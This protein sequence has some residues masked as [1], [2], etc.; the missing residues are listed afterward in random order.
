MSLGPLPV[1]VALLL[2]MVALLVAAGVGRL[3]ER[4][5]QT[6]IGNVLTDMLIAAVLVARIVRA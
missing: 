5:Q 6:G 2:L 1:P 4:R 3:V